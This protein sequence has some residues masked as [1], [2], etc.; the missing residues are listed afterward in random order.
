[1]S[2]SQEELIRL[3]NNPARGIN[4]VLDRVENTWF[5]KKVEINSKTH[6]FVLA[7]DLIIGTTHALLNRVDDGIS[8]LFPPH[9]RNIT[10]LSKHMSD[11]E[12]VGIFAVP[13]T[14]TLQ[15]GIEEQTLLSIAKEDHEKMGRSEFIYRTLLIPKD[16]EVEINGFR[17]SILNGVKIRYS[18]KTGYQVVYDDATNNSFYPIQ[19]NLL[20]RERVVINNKT[21]LKVDIPAYQLECKATEGIT[22]NEGSGCNGTIEYDD[23]FFACKAYLLRDGQLVEMR[24]IYD[25]DVFDPLTPTLSLNI[26]TTNRRI[27]YSIPDVYISNG[28]GVGSLRIYLYSTKG[29]LSRDLTNVD[30]TTIGVDYQDYRYG[31]GHLSEY[32]SG[33]RTVGGIAWRAL[34]VVTGGRNARTFTEIKRDFIEGRRQRALPI[35]EVNLEG[36]VENY[37]YSAVKSIDY[38]TGRSYNLTKELPIQD[39]KKFYSSMGCY[40]GSH[41]TTIEGLVRSGVVIDNGSRVTIP[42]KTLFDITNPTSQLINKLTKDR[43]L[44]L[45]NEE[46][47]KLVKERSMVY[48]PFHYVIDTTSHQ[49]ILRTYHLENPKFLY[50]SFKRENSALALE[51]G[52]GAIGVE[53]K[54]NGYLITLVTESGTNYKDLDN[55]QVGIQ[56]M[57]DPQNSVS[58]AVLPGKL[59]GINPEGERVFEFFL[60][61]RFDIDINNVLYLTN[62]YQFGQLQPSTGIN[63]ELDIGF[64]FVVA[65]ERD[66][67]ATEID[68]LI[69]EN[70]FPN[71]MVG[72]IETQYRV[73]LGKEMNNLYSRIRPVVGPGLFKRYKSDVPAVYKENVFEYKNGELV[74]E[75]GEAVIKHR[76]GEVVKTS[77]GETVYQFLKGDVVMEGG[78]PVQEEP[79][80]LNYHWDFIGFDAAYY[81]SRDEYDKEFAVGIKDYFVDVIDKD[82]HSFTK[83]TLD[84]TA[85]AFQPRN[86]MGF[87]QVL[88]N[89]NFKSFMKLELSFVVTYYLTSDGFR[90][91]N[92]KTSLYQ[93]TP[94]VLNESLYGKTTISVSDL[95]EEIKQNLPHDVVALKISALAGNSLIDVVSNVDKLSGFGIKK[96]LA[97]GGDSLLTIKEDVEVVFLPHDTRQLLED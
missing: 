54:D 12:R 75:N 29:E 40:V 4:Q 19:N 93:S 88:I 96:M 66:Q 64:V 13:S 11:E 73:V 78:L 61:S 77:K 89:N 28:L 67:T 55:S 45:G 53:L 34:D 65:G 26:D 25:E 62:I 84:R 18:D 32:S 27:K 83:S 9:A 47:V 72:I 51:V 94:R 38:V 60:E 20:N 16:T 6:P 8:K 70:I 90:N 14:V 21:F 7:T 50:Q 39:N 63:L 48:T 58:K 3:A 15:F 42:H 57:L 86:K 56:L 68:A 30:I 79:R 59:V 52:V 17:F 49:A 23:Y 24:V 91:Q 2:L 76:A 31:L 81:F 22:S 95:T 36:M 5:D 74:I 80:K 33:L 44:A 41:M 87:Q 85:L 43:Y 92:L 46:K 71:P 82:M 37:G 69:A 35:T 97:L 1:M 10:D